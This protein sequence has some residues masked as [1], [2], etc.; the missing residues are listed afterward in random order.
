MQ[1]KNQNFDDNR[2]LKFEGDYEPNGK[3]KEYYD[4]GSVKFE[5][6]YRNKNKWSGK[7]YDKNK[8]IIY[9]LNNGTGTIMVYY[10]NG[11]LKY[12]GE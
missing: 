9:E 11:I 7:G 3:G 2:I 5:G 6:E 8:I 4:N 12:E 10:N 1:L